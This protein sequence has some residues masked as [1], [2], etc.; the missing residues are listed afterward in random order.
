M[1]IETKITGETTEING[2]KNQKKR[3]THTRKLFGMLICLFSML[4]DGWTVCSG[5]KCQQDV[6]VNSTKT[7]TQQR[8]VQTFSF[9]T[10]LPLWCLK[11]IKCPLFL[12]GL[13]ARICKCE[14]KVNVQAINQTIGKK[15]RLFFPDRKIKVGGM[16]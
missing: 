7:K 4:T 12:S 9:S 13:T 3:D 16:F 14:F 2:V 6:T 1:K 15:S 8:L 10:V 11:D 5:R